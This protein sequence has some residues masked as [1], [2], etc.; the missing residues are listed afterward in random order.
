MK[1]ALS[2]EYERTTEMLHHHLDWYPGF[3]AG[4]PPFGTDCYSNLTLQR[5]AHITDV[6]N[7]SV[8]DL[9]NR[10]H[11]NLAMQLKAPFCQWIE[12]D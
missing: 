5:P 10:R 2:I 12:L 1:Q 8:D 9:K 4:A 6:N 11:D 3:P 7:M